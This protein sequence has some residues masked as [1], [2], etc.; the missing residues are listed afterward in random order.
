MRTR[1]LSGVGLVLAWWVSSAAA[2]GR[3]HSA[4]GQ[5]G[6]RAGRAI[7]TLGRGPGSAASPPPAKRRRRSHTSRVAGA[8]RSAPFNPSGAPAPYTP[9]PRAISTP[10]GPSTPTPTW[11][12][13]GRASAVTL[14]AAG[15]TSPASS[16][17]AAIG[18][19]SRAIANSKSLLPGHQPVLLRRPPRPDGN[20]P[21]L[22][23][24]A[25][26]QLQPG[27]QRRQ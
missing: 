2:Q 10:R 16:S 4:A 12:A 27:L 25:Y 17:P 8:P 21:R 23:V 11:A 18:S 19:R 6:H 13:S 3:Y 14:G 9:I 1:V 20:S 5:P 15:E 26:P 22:H 7:V 24:A